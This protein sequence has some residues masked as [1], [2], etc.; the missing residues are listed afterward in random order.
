VRIALAR[1]ERGGEL[2]A[3]L[4]LWERVSSPKRRRH[5]LALYL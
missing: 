3:H 5:Q 2:R 1:I 4:A